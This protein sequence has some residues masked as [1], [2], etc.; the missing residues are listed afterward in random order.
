MLY[1]IGMPVAWAISDREDADTIEAYWTAVK[2]RC[3]EAVVS[4]LMTDDGKVTST[5]HDYYNNHFVIQI[6][7]ELLPAH[8]CIHK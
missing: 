1:I 6:W 8:V 5:V 3:P 7:Q 2:T 4:N